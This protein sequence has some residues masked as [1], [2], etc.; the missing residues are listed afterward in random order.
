MQV[1]MQVQMLQIRSCRAAVAP[2]R[3]GC[4][5][6]QVEQQ[7]QAQFWICQYSQLGC[8]WETRRWQALL[9]SKAV[10]SLVLGAS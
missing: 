5:L 10:V 6:Q 9:R 8:T 4:K 7:Q 3:Q 1:Q 2:R